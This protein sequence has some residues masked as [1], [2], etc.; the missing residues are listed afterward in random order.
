MKRLFWKT[1]IGV[2]LVLLLTAPAWALKAVAPGTLN[3][4]EGEARLENQPL[5]KDSIGSVD[6]RPGQ[7]LN[8]GTEGKT[9]VLL[10]PGQIFRLGDNSSARM[11]SNHPPELELT[12]GEAIVQV[13]PNRTGAVLVREAG[14]T[15]RLE[16]AGLYFFDADRARV[17][18][19]KGEAEVQSGNQ[20]VTVKSGRA[21]ELNQNG[22]LK[23]TKFDKKEL[24]RNELVQFSGLRSEYL[25]EA[26]ADAAH[27]YYRN[28]AGWYGPGWYWSP[29]FWTYTYV[30]G[31]D[32]FCDPFGWCF[33]S[34]MWALNSP[35]LYTGFFGDF[36]VGC[37]GH[38][39]IG[40]ERLPISFTALPRPGATGASAP[41]PA[42]A[43]NAGTLRGTTGGT[44]GATQG[45][46]INH[47]GFNRGTIGSGG[48]R[49]GGGVSSSGGSVSGGALSGAHAAGGPVSSGSSGAHAPAGGGS[50]GGAHGGGFGGGAL[51]GGHR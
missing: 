40:R 35:F 34:P 1:L 2:L 45:A 13:L 16:K 49:G 11:I 24:E 10:G 31:G 3:Y 43:G 7:V 47:S 25:A 42:M 38:T 21:V 46:V 19:Y 5:D 20:T 50:V 6:L 26:N 36:G 17:F 33:Y 22:N 41:P 4:A 23:A 9:E 44:S 14:A 29:A 39:H 51:G 37:F 12:Q 48:L 32:Y 8:T 30:P 27:R 15:A 28:S 18:V